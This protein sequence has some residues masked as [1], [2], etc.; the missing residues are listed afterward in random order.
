MTPA[1][2]ENVQEY[3]EGWD[4]YDPIVEY[5]RLGVGSKDSN[6]RFSHCNRDYS[7]FSLFIQF[8][9]FYL[10]VNFIFFSLGIHKDV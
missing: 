6:W 3:D 5:Q 1:Y 4:L 9:F 2:R 10:K 7:V 8:L